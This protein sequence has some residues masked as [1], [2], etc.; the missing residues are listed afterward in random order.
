[1]KTRGDVEHF[2]LLLYG[3]LHAQS[4]RNVTL[5]HVKQEQR[6]VEYALLLLSSVQF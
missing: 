4:A 1:M 5:A 3:Y 2:E 6:R